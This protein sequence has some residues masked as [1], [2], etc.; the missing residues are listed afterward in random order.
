VKKDN[1]DILRIIKKEKIEKKDFE[2]EDPVTCSVCGGC[3]DFIVTLKCVW[4]P[5]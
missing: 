2:G 4:R 5:L 1:K 3:W